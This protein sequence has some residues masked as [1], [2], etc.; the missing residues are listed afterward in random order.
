[1]SSY[2][3]LAVFWCGFFIILRKVR[4]PTRSEPPARYEPDNILHLLEVS[5]KLHQ[6]TERYRQ[7]DTMLTNINLISADNEKG[8]SLAIPD[9][10]GKTAQ[11]D[12]ICAESDTDN[13]T[14]AL[15]EERQ[16]LKAEI[17]KTAESIGESLAS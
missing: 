11:Y 2:I 9:L 17:I 6:L 14:A 8:I 1:M 5:D 15:T 4:E 10:T 13:F 16:R 12:F 3:V 7:I